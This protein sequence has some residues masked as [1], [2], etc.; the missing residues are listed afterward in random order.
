MQAI[1]FACRLLARLGE[2]ELPL[3]SQQVL[4]AVAA[5]LET[6]PDIARFTGLSSSSSS[7][8][9]RSLAHKGYLSR[10]GGSQAVYLLAPAGKERVRQYFSF[11][12]GG[13]R[14]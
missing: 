4:L 5:G 11:L 9:L 12:P 1:D 13:G 14:P 7:G 3:P 10:V 2:D 8:V 6:A